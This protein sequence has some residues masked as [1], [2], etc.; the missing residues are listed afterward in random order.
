MRRDGR[1][2]SVIVA[3]YNIENYLPRCMDSLLAQTYSP[4]E[5]ILVDDGSSD[6]TPR[7]CDEYARKNDFVHVIHKENGGL[8][9]AR[10]AG[11]AIAKG[12][13]I[14]YVDG[15]DTVEADMYENL[16][17][18]CQRTGAQIAI[19]AYR[20][21][22]EGAKENHST[23][24]KL[25]LSREE[26]LELYINGDP[27]YHIYNSVWSKLF[28]RKVIEDIRF[29]EGRKSEDIMYT[30][31]ALT[32]A[33]KCIFLDTPYYN[34]T[35]DR[36]GS[37][38]NNQLQLHERRFQDEIPFWKEQAD[39]LRMLGMQ[40]LAEKSAYQFYRRMLFY[41]IDFRD[42][43]MKDSAKELIAFLRK[44]KCEIRRIY[45]KNFVALGDKVRMNL[46]LRLPRAY[47]RLVKIYDKFIIPLRQHMG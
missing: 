31:R 4:M 35:V 21:V 36:S 42:R 16:L 43:K 10:N 23:G 28:E 2:I 40:E 30:T 33:S 41:Y 27:Q 18:A 7:L 22:G 26:A 34:Y 13:Y 39:H 12:D 20:E 9:S 1:L 29:P 5:I 32:R 44:E 45:R 17:G 46:A 6:E 19:C 8:S 11:L 15:D 24:N 37:I 47:Y 25:E 14:G 3:A 38:M